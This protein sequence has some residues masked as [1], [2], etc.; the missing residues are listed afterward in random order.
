MQIHKLAP[1]DESR[2][3]ALAHAHG[4]VFHT[5]A[6]T[7]LF[8]GRLQ[9]YGLYDEGGDLI[10]GFVLY[11]DRRF[12][13]RL[14]CNP[15]FTPEVGPFLRVAASNPVKVA[16]I[17]KTA[18]SRMCELLESLP[19]AVV[20]ISLH[21]HVVDLQPFVWKH[22][23]VV[24]G[25]TY[26]LDL[27]VPLDEIWAGMSNERRKNI[28][29]ARRDGVRVE[30]AQALARVEELARATFARQGVKIAE[31]VL[32]RVLFDFADE[33]NSFAFVAYRDTRP[34]AAAFC[35]SDQTTAYYL[36][37]GHEPDGGH[38]GAG[39][40]CL[41]EAIS[42]AKRRGLLYFDFEGSMNPNIERFFRGFGG[43]LTPYFRANKARLPLEMVLKFFNRSLF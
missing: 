41:W 22:F 4:T 29:K 10:G 37:G 3:D 5:L 26:V 11:H 30:P 42:E 33:E 39:A 8:D 35:I 34:V 16:E 2:Y 1:C 25:Y 20:S 38:T 17:W 28:K 31:D 32:R 13:G 15:P 43:R 19:Y 23:K 18:L 36:F 24:P 9:R 27:S 14:Y 21:K 6:W 12:G 7:N 40:L